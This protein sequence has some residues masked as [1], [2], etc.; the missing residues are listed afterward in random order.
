M[1]DILKCLT[2]D[3]NDDML[4]INYV[5]DDVNIGDISNVATVNYTNNSTVKIQKKST[6]KLQANKIKKSIKILNKK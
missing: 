5:D 2:K 6:A 3:T 1:R 4:T